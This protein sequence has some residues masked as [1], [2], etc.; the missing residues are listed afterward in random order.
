MSGVLSA[1]TRSSKKG[2]KSL[3]P[4]CQRATACHINQQRSSSTETVPPFRKILVANRGEIA[5]RVLRT[6]R[7]HNMKTV[8]IYSTADAKSV[9][10][11]LMCPYAALNAQYSDI[12]KL[13]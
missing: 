2:T 11:L 9:S 4:S 8:A 6:A 10:A 12:Y 7:E 13:I 1:I 3:V 5:L